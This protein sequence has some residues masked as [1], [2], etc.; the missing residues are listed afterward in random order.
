MEKELKKMEGKK[1][2][3]ESKITF[4]GTAKAISLA[5][6]LSPKS[7]RRKDKIATSTAQ[8]KV[9]YVY[10]REI[11]LSL[12]EKGISRRG[13]S[14]KFWKAFFSKPL[15]R[16]ENSLLKSMLFTRD[17]LTCHLIGWQLCCQS[18]RSQVWKLMNILDFIMYV[19]HNNSYKLV[20][21][22]VFNYNWCLIS[23]LIHQ[24]GQGKYTHYM[25]IIMFNDS[26]IQVRPTIQWSTD[27]AGNNAKVCQHVWE[28]KNMA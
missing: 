10:I 23:W 6:K 7:Q 21:W 16:E 14:R 26:C 9:C 12:G 22:Q 1:E 19:Q 3:K 11:M 13:Y 28:R 20:I 2:L 27:S 15:T 18:I 25:Q 24:T 4:K 8:L 17:N 5:A